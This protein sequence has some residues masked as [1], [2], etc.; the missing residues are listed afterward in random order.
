M[1]WRWNEDAKRYQNTST[2]KFLPQKRAQEY[3]EESIIASSAVTATL[4]SMVRGDPP[5]LSSL[6]WKD[7]MRQEIKDEYIRQYLLGRGGISQMTQAD[8]GSIGGMLKK[9]YT[10]LERFGN[11]VD[12]GRLSEARNGGING[13]S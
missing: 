3:V 11:E 10:Y 12:L 4:A 13:P 2:G 7:A 8:W 6:G 1:P 9:Q 5:K